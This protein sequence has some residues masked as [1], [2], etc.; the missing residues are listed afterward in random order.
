[1]EAETLPGLFR[2]SH[3]FSSMLDNGGAVAHNQQLVCHYHAAYSHTLYLVRD[4]K[5]KGA[6]VMAFFRPL[7]RWTLTLAT[8]YHEPLSHRAEGRCSDIHIYDERRVWG[9]SVCVS[10]QQVVEAFP[11]S[12]GRYLKIA[13]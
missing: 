3:S 10:A 4:M 12:Y 11:L 1:M 8:L 6:P 2:G 5:G 13:Y 9:V 7:H